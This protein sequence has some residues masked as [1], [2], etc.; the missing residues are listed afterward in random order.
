MRKRMGVAAAA[1]ALT[2]L[3]TLVGPVK[4][5]HAASVVVCEENETW[6]FSPPPGLTTSIV[7]GAFNYNYTGLCVGA[8][9]NALVPHT[10]PNGGGFGGAYFGNCVIA[11]LSPGPGFAGVLVGGVVAVIAVSVNGTV[12][13]HVSV[14]VPLNPCADSGPTPAIGAT[15]FVTFP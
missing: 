2:M 11:T 3:G 15:A 10:F 1:L 4:T 14:L 5:V 9:R 8:A 7:T 13:P 12:G 6:N